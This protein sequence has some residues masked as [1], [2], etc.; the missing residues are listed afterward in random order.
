M[1]TEWRTDAACRSDRTEPAVEGLFFAPDGERA[2]EREIREQLAKAVCARCPVLAPCE[3]QALAAQEPYGVW[4]GLTE[5]DR[6]RRL[7]RRLPGMHVERYPPRVP[8]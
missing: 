1:D 5:A 7:G 6:A 3:A 8:R 2:V 4:G